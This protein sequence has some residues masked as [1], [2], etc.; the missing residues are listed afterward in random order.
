MI[1]E[2]MENG[3]IFN[4]IQDHSGNR[5]GLVI[6][7][8]SYSGKSQ[9]ILP[10]SQLADAAEGLHYLHEHKIIHGDIKGVR[11]NLMRCVFH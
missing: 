3:N 8:C 7:L 4:F 9:L 1:S 10:S 6:V 5:L 2:L 11:P